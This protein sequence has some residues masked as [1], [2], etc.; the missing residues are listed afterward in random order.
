[1]WSLLPRTRR[2]CRPCPQSRVLSNVPAPI[3]WKAPPGTFFLGMFSF[4]KRVQN[5]IGMSVC[6]EVGGGALP[7]HLPFLKHAVFLQGHG[8][9]PRVPQVFWGRTAL[10]LSLLPLVPLTAMVTP[11]GVV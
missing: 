10:R 3:S 6:I 7:S 2:V 11:R 4:W 8:R 1:M 9:D 5:R